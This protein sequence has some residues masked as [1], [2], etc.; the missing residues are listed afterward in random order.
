MAAASPE[1]AGR[2]RLGGIDWHF[3]TQRPQHLASALAGAGHRV[4]Y[5][6]NNLADSATPGFRIEPDATGRLFQANLHAP[7]AP[8]IYYGAPSRQTIS[9]LRRSVGE[10]MQW[11]DSDGGLCIVQHLFWLDIAAALPGSALLYDCMDHHAGFENNAACVL[12][13]EERLIADADLL[14]VT[15]DWLDRKLADANP[16]RVLIRNATTDI[17]ANGRGGCIAI[18]AGA[19]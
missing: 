19:G 3:R 8:E 9:D 15:S 1:R 10:L 13:A 16:H 7:G 12:G 17:S 5:L 11:A 18:R 6:S 2:V 4:F 14:I